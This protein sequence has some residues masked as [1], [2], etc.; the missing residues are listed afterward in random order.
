MRIE[1]FYDV[2]SP[3]SYCAFETLLRYA[4]RWGAELVLRPFFLGG[5]MKAVDNAP[6]ITLA[7][8]APYLTSDFQRV[9]RHHGLDL[10]V[11]A[12]FPVNT[13][14][15]Q[16][17]LTQV[18][19]HHPDLLEQTSRVFWR[20]LWSGEEV[21]MQEPEGIEPLLL[22]AGFGTTEAET[23]IEGTQ[24]PDVKARLLATSNEAVSRGAFGA[25]TIFASEGGETKMY[26]G[27]DRLPLLAFE[28]DLDWSGPQPG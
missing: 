4:P 9:G 14:L 3:Y 28:H 21:R 1:L 17:V 23:L 7:A 5:V 10:H 12:G 18:E 20:A 24:H 11:P 8:R 26:F 16:R 19:E 13:L 6:P 27:Q 2:V 22:E 25:P 15:A